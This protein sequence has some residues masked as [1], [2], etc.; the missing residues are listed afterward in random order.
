MSSAK[1]RAAAAGVQVAHDRAGDDDA[2]RPGGA[3]DQPEGEQQPDV[4]RH[5]TQQRGGHVGG[6]ADEQRGPAPAEIADRAGHELPAGQAEHRRGDRQ[7]HSPRGRRE[8]AGHRRQA[9]Q[10]EVHRQRA[11]GRQ[12]A[13]HE[14]EPTM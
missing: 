7:L 3:L 2:G 5:G 10:I 4:G 8:V 1:K 12:R 9:R 11:E 13:E 14:H 6:Q